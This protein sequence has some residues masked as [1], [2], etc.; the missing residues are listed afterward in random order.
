MTHEQL[1]SVLE[2]AQELINGEK[3]EDYGDAYKS[4]T[5][6]ANLWAEILDTEVSPAQVALC[7]IQ[8][9]VA[10]YIHGGYKRDTVVDIAGYAGCLEKIYLTQKD[11]EYMVK[12]FLEEATD[13]GT[14]MLP[15]WE[16]VDVGIPIFRPDSDQDWEPVF[17]PDSTWTLEHSGQVLYN[18]HL[19]TQCL[20]GPC[21]IHQMTDHSMRS[22]PQSWRE[23]MRYME[24]ICPHNIG[25][26]DPDDHLAPV[27]HSCDG[28]CKK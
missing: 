16:A 18:V 19:R 10:R 1:R 12:A 28:C 17:D 4:F 3:R 22:F 27:P 25:H 2:E 6:I 8:L 21:P 11:D 5:T 7:L 20:S 9:K 26:P 14:P 15:L 23:D 24:R 13:V